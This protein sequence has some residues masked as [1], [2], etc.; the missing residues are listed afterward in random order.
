MLALLTG[1]PRKVAEQLAPWSDL[2]RSF[3][4]AELLLAAADDLADRPDSCGRRLEALAAEWSAEPVYAWLLACHLLARARHRDTAAVLARWPRSDGPARD[5]RPLFLEGL[6]ALAQGRAPALPDD[7]EREPGASAEVAVAA[8][9][10]TLGPAAWGFLR[11]RAAWLRGDGQACHDLC[12]QLGAEGDSERLANLRTRAACTL[13]GD[14]ADWRPQPV[15]PE[16]C[17]PAA[18]QLHLARDEA[19][20]AQGLLAAQARLHPDDLVVCWLA[21]GFWLEPVRSWIS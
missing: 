13:D 21:P 8:G 11:A 10:P 15:M 4:R 6:L 12:R 17:L 5:W 19:E 1:E 20:A 14:G 16:A 9:G 2:A 18:V 3:A 7:L